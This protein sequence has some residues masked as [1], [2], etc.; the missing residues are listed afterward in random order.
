MHRDTNNHRAM[1]DVELHAL[2]QTSEPNVRQVI[3]EA[4]LVL[5]LRGRQLS[6][7][8]NT[9]PG[10]DIHYESNASGQMWW[11]A[12]LRRTLTLE[13]ATAGIMRTVRQENAIALASTLAWQSALLHSTRPPHAPPTGD[14]A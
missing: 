12:E 4:A 14:T 1:T 8:R 2:I 11:T 5:D 3:A 13:M 6:V 9:Y 7:L 10:W